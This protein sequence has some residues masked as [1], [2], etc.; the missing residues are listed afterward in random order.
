MPFHS[1]LIHFYIVLPIFLY[2]LSG[3]CRLCLIP[4]VFI[5]RQAYSRARLLLQCFQF[6]LKSCR[7]QTHSPV[8]YES[9]ISSVSFLSLFR[10]Q[11][12]LLVTSLIQLPT[13]ITQHNQKDNRGP[14]CHLYIAILKRIWIKHFQKLSFVGYTTKRM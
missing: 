12:S 5:F 2:K 7:G 3:K 6:I 9:L 4:R 1:Y 14:L 10:L 13:Q 11:K 8:R